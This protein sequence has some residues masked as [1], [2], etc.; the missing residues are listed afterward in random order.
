MGPLLH[1]LSNFLFQNEI[2][3][4]LLMRRAWQ[5]ENVWALG[6]LVQLPTVKG[7]WGK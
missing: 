2:S 5:Q 4:L 6:H 7:G 1:L 3:K